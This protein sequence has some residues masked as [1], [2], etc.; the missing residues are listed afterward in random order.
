MPIDCTAI[1]I[2]PVTGDI[3]MAVQL[4]PSVV[5]LQVND[6][7]ITCDLGMEFRHILDNILNLDNFSLYYNSSGITDQIQDTHDIYE[8]IM[9]TPTEEIIPDTN[10][11]AVMSFK[12]LDLDNGELALSFNQPINT[13]TLNFANLSLQSSPFQEAITLVVPLS[14]GNCSDGCEIGRHVTLSMNP[15][16]LDKLKLEDGVCTYISNCYLYYTDPFVEDFGGNAIVKY[17][18]CTNNLLQN[19]TLDVTSPS[20]SAC[21]LDLSMD[22]LTVEF[23]EPI[24]ASSFTPSGINISTAIESVILTS[25]SVINGPS[26]FVMVIDLGFDSDKIKTSLSIEN[27][28]ITVSL[29]P[30]AFEDVAGN[31]I[32]SITMLCTFINDT[33]S[34]NVSSFIL[35]LNSNILQIIFDEPILMDHMN[36]SG[37]MLTDATGV[38]VVSLGDS[39]LL[40]FDDIKLI[41]DCN[42]LHDSTELRTVY[43]A[44]KNESLTAVKTNNIFTFLLIDDDSIFDLNSNGFISGGPMAA[45]DVIADNSPATLVNFS[46]DMNIGQFV[47]TFNDVV[48]VSTLRLNEIFIQ[49]SVYSTSAKYVP[50][51]SYNRIDS[52]VI[53][54]NLYVYSVLQLKEKLLS[55]LATDINSTYLIIRAHAINDICGVD[56]IAITNGN[57][58]IASSYIRDSEPPVLESFSLDM[59]ASRIWFTFNEPIDRYRFNITLFS[60]QADS[61]GITN[62]SIKF[63]TSG[64]YLRYSPS[65]YSTRFTYQLSSS[66]IRLVYS[67]PLI[68]HNASTTN[69]VILQGGI[70]DASGNSISTT[71]PVSPNSFTP[72]RRKFI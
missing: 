28:T 48:D 70:F 32:H 17:S 39:K 54:I 4:P 34:P 3:N 30:A 69:L 18:Y 24:D 6:T 71:G 42:G 40:S 43:I 59:D 36:I 16:D 26:S 20:L 60:M 22:R 47:L 11:P 61:E 57:G 14:D 2:G 68:A 27:D 72:R 35:D 13:T 52:S 21:S 62:A 10:P 67:I 1:L 66:F 5:G 49:N 53:E 31:S 12:S 25:A 63:S 41:N 46:L 65:Y 51:G 15:S 64:V 7:T 37:F 33:I 44:L 19:L 38:T 55:S 29:V 8:N 58:I 45:A 23:D 50:S 9:G 56:I